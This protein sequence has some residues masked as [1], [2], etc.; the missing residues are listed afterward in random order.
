ME[1]C[2]SPAWNDGLLHNR[3]F[4]YLMAVVYMLAR[5][6]IIGFIFHKLSLESF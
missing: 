1:L 4:R 6:T 5:L 2:T 3:A